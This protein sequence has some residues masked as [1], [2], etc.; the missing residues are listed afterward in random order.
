AQELHE[1]IAENAHRPEESHRQAERNADQAPE[2]EP[3]RD[4]LEADADVRRER[5]RPGELA[6]R[7][8]GLQRPGEERRAELG[9]RHRPYDDARE[10]RDAG[11]NDSPPGQKSVLDGATA[12]MIEGS[13]N[14]STSFFGSLVGKRPAPAPHSAMLSSCS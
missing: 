3:D 14:S 12:L 11:E 2:H 6:Q 8:D 5:A 10:E 4:A 1:R 13:I 7:L 9:A